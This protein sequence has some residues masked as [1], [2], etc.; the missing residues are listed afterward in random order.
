MIHNTDLPGPPSSV[1]RPS[2]LLRMLRGIL[3]KRRDPG[4]LRSALFVVAAG[5]PLVTS[6]AILFA[7]PPGNLAVNGSG[8]VILPRNTVSHPAAP[9]MWRAPESDASHASEQ[10]IRRRDGQHPTHAR[11]TLRRPV[12]SQSLPPETPAAA[13]ATVNFRRSDGQI[14][15]RPA[16]AGSQKWPGRVQTNGSVAIPQNSDLS[17]PEVPLP[18]GPAEQATQLIYS[19]DHAPKSERSASDTSD[20]G[21]GYLPGPHNHGYAP[22][23]SGFRATVECDAPPWMES[24]YGRT[25][26][27]S[28]GQEASP[29]PAPSVTLPIDFVAWWDPLIRE[30]AGLSTNTLPVEV[31]TLVQQ[32]LAHAPQVQVLQADPEVQYTIVRQEEAAFDWR[33]FLDAK[34][35]DLN[36]PVGSTLT[37]GNNDN[38][39]VDNKVNSQGGFKRRTAAGGELQIAQ[40][41]GHQYN[42]SRFLLP[43]PQSTS[44]LELS[45]RQPILSH[46]GTVY[47]QNQIVLAGINSNAASD[48]SL[49]ELQTHLFSVAES[50]WS[51]YKARA[52]F[53]QRQK[54]LS[55][56]QHVLQ[57]LEGRNQVDTIPRQ[58]LRARAAVARAESRLQRAVTDIRNTESRLRLLVN[59][60]SM[61]NSGPLEFTPAESPA[62]MPSP[63]G[64]RE[65]LE[66]ALVNRPDISRA[67]REMRA[68][69]V[70]I[71]VSENE[72]LPRLDFLVTS[73]VAGLQ[74]QSQIGDALVDQFSD[75][76]PGYTIGLEFEVPLGN[77]AAKA[78]LEQRRWELKRA[79]SA[80]RVTVETS[81]TEV[82]IATREVDT[83]YRE[84]LGK[85]QAM[86]AAQN[87]VAYLQDRFSVLPRVEDSTMLL[88][89]D[90]LDG[91]ERLADE[92]SSFVE[93]QVGY[94][95]SI[96]QLRRMT[97][98]LMRSRHDVPQLDRE[99]SEWM[100]ARAEQTVEETEARASRTV[101]FRRIDTPDKPV[102]APPA[103]AKPVPVRTGH[104][105]KRAE[106][107]E[108]SAASGSAVRPASPAGHSFGN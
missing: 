55:S 80:F 53:F 43:N 6:V 36:D 8:I 48:E 99:E 89:E 9:P 2:D 78:K 38:R 73:Y 66:T 44:R 45:F 70:R 62:A 13:S 25:G 100:S 50:Y 31:S 49:Q 57:T 26:Q 7:A 87:E 101:S 58:I 65:S 19:A 4:F 103:V 24:Y 52:E 29:T 90:L 84:M 83:S 106:L 12:P 16:G 30:S 79:I 68:S 15:I 10:G 54:L 18:P 67:I 71:G 95:L 81:L 108:S 98:T 96:I 93:S 86:V 60:P 40:S 3:R 107:P 22:G 23:T 34:Y 97:G 102:S 104:S 51:L 105:V 56:A 17:V 91:Y 61:L 94:A 1:T 14:V 28:R 32:A 5:L 92:E 33:A 69:S 41:L 47:N 82:E 20:A 11:A 64:L 59:D 85:Y 76:R 37:T 21:N 75:G 35:N 42:N 77:R 74:N 39:F 63:T 72:L 88:L 27:M 46:S